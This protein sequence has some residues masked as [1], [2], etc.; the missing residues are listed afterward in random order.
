MQTLRKKTHKGRLSFVINPLQTIWKGKYAGVA[1]EN[2]RVTESQIKAA[3][4]A[5]KRTIKKNGEL[6]IRINPNISVS[7]KPAEVRMGKGKG[8]FS[9]FIAR[10][11]TG[12]IIFELDTFQNSDN[13]TTILPPVREEGSVPGNEGFISTIDSKKG[14]EDLL[15][16]QAF[17]VAA[18]KLPLKLRFIKL[19]N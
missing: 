1:L 17:K 11:K 3:E 7:S 5:I 2:A 12:S 19:D 13:T 4:L 9:H 8:N 6:W 18:S 15:A 10:V 16:R 14:G